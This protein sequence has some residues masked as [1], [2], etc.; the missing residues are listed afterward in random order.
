MIW[1][2]WAPPRVKFFHWKANI[3]RCWTAE[4]LAR[5]GLQHHPRCLLCDQMPETIQHLSAGCS[6]TR[7]V[8][9]DILSWLRMTCTPPTADD[10]LFDWWDAAKQR[11]P[12]PLRKALGSVTLLIPWMVWKHRNMCVFDRAPPSASN[13]THQIKDEMAAWVKAGARR[14]GMCTDSFFC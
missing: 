9:H 10:T 14:P 12:K 6:F 7:Q 8:W 13:L 2:C 1:K 11:T 4:R 3:D 5:R